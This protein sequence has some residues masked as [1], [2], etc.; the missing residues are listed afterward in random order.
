M[1]NLGAVPAAPSKSL[2][3]LEARAAVDFATMLR[4]LIRGESRSVAQQTDSLTVVVPGFGSGDA[5]TLPLRR[6]LK[7]NGVRSEGWGLGTNLGGSNLPH[8]Q[9]DLSS[10]WDFE[11]LEE[12]RGEV[13]VPFL[14]DRLYDAV[15]ARHT[16]TGKKI[17]LVGW[18]LGGF[19]AREVARELPDV[20]DKVVTMGSPLIGGPKYTA[21]APVFRRRGTDLDWIEA[22]IAR[23]EETVPPIS[24]PITAIISKTDGIVDWNAV[25]DHKSPKV[26]HI[27]VDASHL[28]MGFNTKIWS[29]VLGA[30]LSR[31]Q[32]NTA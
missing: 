17:S 14:I 9:E 26:R 3:F 13:A 27:E 30:L 24:Q 6:F 25:Y 16:A 4:P 10:R 23:R 29:Y 12:Y 2:L 28:G 31:D 7:Q 20:V 22:E 15:M 11:H 21:A 5:Y 1:S 8:T 18:S 32:E 19:L